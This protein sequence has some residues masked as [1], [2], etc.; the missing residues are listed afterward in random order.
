M[1]YVINC[2]CGYVVRGETE[3]E[4]VANAEAHVQDAHPDMIG[5]VSREEF[6]AMAEEQ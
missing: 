4:L 5:Q 2:D 1:A 6:L 3:D